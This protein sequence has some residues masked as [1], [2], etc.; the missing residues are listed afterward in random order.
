MDVTVVLCIILVLHVFVAAPPVSSVASA[1]TSVP[2]PAADGNLL[3]NVLDD[4]GTGTDFASSGTPTNSL[5]VTPGSEEGFAKFLV[6]NNGVLFENDIL[7]IGVKSEY[8]KNLGM[9]VYIHMY[10]V[11]K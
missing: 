6:K 8:K 3:V 2:A 4:F 5:E 11:V 7:Q 1:V 9:Y 10:A